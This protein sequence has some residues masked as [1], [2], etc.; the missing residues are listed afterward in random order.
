MTRFF[1]TVYAVALSSLLLTLISALVTGVHMPFS[2]F[3]CLLFGLLLVMLPNVLQK[4]VDR[5]TLFTLLGAAAALL[6]FLPILLL[7]GPVSQ[8]IFYAASLAAAAILLL[9]LRHNTTHN[10]FKARFGFVTV[11]VLCVLAYFILSTSWLVPSKDSVYSKP[12]LDPDRVKLALNDIIPYVIVHLAAGVLCL[13]GLRAQHGNVDEK[14]FQR[15]QLRDAMIFITVVSTVFV[16][17]PYLKTIWDY[18]LNTAIAPFLRMIARVIEAVF[19]GATKPG[20]QPMSSAP[21]PTEAPTT[22][23]PEITQPLGTPSP[24][25]EPAFSQE[26]PPP[27]HLKSDT[28]LRLVLTS[29]IFAAVIL[30]VSIVL[31]KLLRRLKR[32][33]R[34]Y[35]NESCEALPK[36]EEPKK[37]AKPAKHSADPRKRMRYLYAD[38]LKRLRR[39]SAQRKS[40][41]SGPDDP[42]SQALNTDY[43]GET[44]N[45][46]YSW[47]KANMTALPAQSS[48]FGNI[49]TRDEGIEREAAATVMKWFDRRARQKKNVGISKIFK[50]NTCGEIESSAE[51]LLR[52]E[53]SDLNDF[54]KLYEQ[55]RY[56]MQQD[57]TEADASRM[58]AAYD[59][60][61][62]SSDALRGR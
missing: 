56:R 44:S 26:T 4:W 54:T 27:A 24:V 28:I 48:S 2:A 25:S 18:L 52:A 14:R 29:L 3:A 5:G 7:H 11:V 13:R 10:N 17:A 50:T 12:I 15:R 22:A 19:A 59:R 32:D 53:K 37:E 42:A 40:P 8:Y 57:P 21:V 34:S 33:D 31:V 9:L 23:V 49:K 55:A 58:K 62:Q 61:K 51:A 36:T 30:I 16:A 39:I 47:T 38:Y 20:E 35:P 6:G 46:G 1:R 43:W 60:V 45:S 41:A